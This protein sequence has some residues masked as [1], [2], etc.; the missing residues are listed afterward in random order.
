LRHDGKNERKENRAEDEPFLMGH[1][2]LR[3]YSIF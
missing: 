1:G 3:F 2:D